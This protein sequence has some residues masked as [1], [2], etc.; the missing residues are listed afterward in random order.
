MYTKQLPTNL[1]CPFWGVQMPHGVPNLIF[2]PSL[3]CVKF[4]LSS[5]TPPPILILLQ[6]PRNISYPW[7]AHAVIG[8]H[9]G[10]LNNSEKVFWEFGAIIMLNASYFFLFFCTPKWPSDHVSANQEYK[11]LL[12]LTTMIMMRTNKIIK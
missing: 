9:V 7:L 11:L 4:H 6:N 5:H 3:N 12:K 10:V 2:N 1:G 8:S